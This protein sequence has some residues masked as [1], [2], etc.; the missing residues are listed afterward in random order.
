MPIKGGMAVKTRLPNPQ[1]EGADHGSFHRLLRHRGWRRV[2]GVDLVGVARTAQGASVLI[3][4]QLATDLDDTDLVHESMSQDND[5]T[6]FGDRAKTRQSCRWGVF[7]GYIVE[8]MPLVEAVP[9]Q[10]P[11]FAA[12]KVNVRTLHAERQ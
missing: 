9:L 8:A 2:P 10:G 11:H 7:G 3:H 5:F 6:F 12:E 1:H 4:A